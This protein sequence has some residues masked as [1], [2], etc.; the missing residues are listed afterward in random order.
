MKKTKISLAGKIITLLASLFAILFVSGKWLDIQQVTLIFGDSVQRKYSLFEIADFL[1]AFNFYLESDDVQAFAY[2]FAVG[3]ALVILLCVVNV[4][5]TF[6]DNHTVKVLT[7]IAAVIG[8]IVAAVF[9]ISLN[10]INSEVK[11]ATYGGIYKL[12]KSTAKPF[13]T[14]LFLIVECVGVRLEEKGAPAYNRFTSQAKCPYCGAPAAPGSAF[15]TNCG[16]NISVNTAQSVGAANLSANSGAAQSPKQFCDQ[17][18]QKNT[19]MSNF[20]I[21]C[22]NKLI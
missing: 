15:C 21:Y 6:L 17:C 19:S 8:V 14:P 7:I 22:G 20:C 12:L 3:A 13:L 1:D 10:E 11:E 18:G 4:I 16:K 5:L 9:L 2:F